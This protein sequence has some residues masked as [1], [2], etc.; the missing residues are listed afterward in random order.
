[1]SITLD[2]ADCRLVTALM[3]LARR[4]CVEIPERVPIFCLKRFVPTSG[5]SES[6]LL[7]AWRA[8]VQVAGGLVRPESPCD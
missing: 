2:S 5:S 7:A 8:G 3:I 1:M 6:E 4:R